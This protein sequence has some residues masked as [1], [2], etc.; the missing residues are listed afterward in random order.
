MSWKGGGVERFQSCRAPDTLIDIP[1][2]VPGP[3][4]IVLGWAVADDIGST[5]GEQWFKGD[6]LSM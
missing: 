4:F 5:P 1:K 2:S 6:A 3:V